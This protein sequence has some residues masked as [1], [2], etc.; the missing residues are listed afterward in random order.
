MRIFLAIRKERRNRGSTPHKQN[1]I[2]KGIEDHAAFRYRSPS[3]LLEHIHCRSNLQRGCGEQGDPTHFM[4]CRGGAWWL[5]VAPEPP[6]LLP[7]HGIAPAPP[8]R[9]PPGNVCS[10]YTCLSP[11]PD[12]H[13]QISGDGVRHLHLTHSQGTLNLCLVKSHTA[14][15]EDHHTRPM[16]C[17]SDT[18]DTV[19]WCSSVAPLEV[20]SGDERSH[21]GM[22]TDTCFLKGSGIQMP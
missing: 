13:K 4:I 16:P 20:I 17:P 1:R 12:L 3:V 15:F 19:A 8:S 18:V 11:T 22:W 6:P 2:S 14:R 10:H 9:D 5:R 21:A 7:I